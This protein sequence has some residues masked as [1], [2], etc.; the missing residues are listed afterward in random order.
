MG[1]RAW[2][3]RPKATAKHYL[4]MSK[5]TYPDQAKGKFIV[6]FRPRETVQAGMIREALAQAGVNFYVENEVFS[7]VQMGGMGLGAL[8][9]CV[10]LYNDFKLKDTAFLMMKSFAAAGLVRSLCPEVAVC[11]GE[12]RTN[13]DRHL[14]FGV[15]FI[16]NMKAHLSE[17]YVRRVKETRIPANVFYANDPPTRDFHP[18]YNALMLGAHINSPVGT[19]QERE[20]SM[21]KT[22]S[23]AFVL[24]CLLM[25]FTTG[26]MSIHTAACYGNLASVERHLQK[27]EDVNVR[28]NYGRTPLIWAVD[29]GDLDLVNFLVAKGAD[30][31]AKDKSDKTPLMRAAFKGDLEMVKGLVDKDADVN[32]KDKWGATP[33]MEAAVRGNL[34]MVKGL[35]DKGADVNAR[36]SEEWTPLMK[37]AQ[38]GHLDMLEYLGDKGADVNAR[39]KTYGRTPLIWASSYRDM[40]CRLYARRSTVRNLNMV[41]Y[42]VAK[43]ADVNAKEKNGDTPL[44]WAAGKN[45]LDWVTYLIANGADVNAKNN[46]GRTPIKMAGAH[47]DEPGLLCIAWDIRRNEVVALLM[48]HGA[49]E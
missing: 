19:A 20:D 39:D 2:S 22:A 29:S 24:M 4:P 40:T 32:A 43:G 31:N 42:L 12:D 15:D 13:L 25:V 27:G 46:E 38:V 23:I 14:A 47:D 26:C 16:Q 45:S 35:V 21:K 34:E 8:E 48:Q 6:I 33:L 28:D 18:I 3:G 1:R 30:V 49:R 44:M 10:G 5:H 37:A 36:D 9:K 7:S 17:T 41:K 11:V